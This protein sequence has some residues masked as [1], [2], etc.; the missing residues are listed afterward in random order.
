MKMIRKI[1]K[2]SAL[3][4]IITLVLILIPQLFWGKLFIVGGDDSR[5]Y[6]IFPQQFLDNFVFKIS[7]DNILGNIAGYSPRSFLAPVIYIIFLLKQIPFLNVQLLMY[8]LNLGLGFLFFY[9][10]LG[11]WIKDKKNYSIYIKIIASF[12]Y[13]FSTYLINTLYVN[14]LLAV[15]L[16]FTIP[17]SLYFFLKALEGKNIFLLL[18]SSL[19][20]SIF[21]STFNTLPWSAAVFIVLIPILI[22]EFWKQ[23]KIFIFYSLIFS[24]VTILLNLHWL[25][26]LFY[27]YFNKMGSVS[28]ID[29]YSSEQFKISSNNLIRAVTGIFGQL[30]IIFNERNTLFVKNFSIFI[31]LKE[32][33]ILT[34]VSA[35]IFIK[36]SDIIFRKYY[37]VGLSSLLLAFFFFSPSFG[38]WSVNLF[39]FLNNKIPFFSMFRN[40]YDKFSF[41]LAF[42]YSFSFAISLV[43]IV[44]IIKSKKTIQLFLLLISIIIFLNASSFIFQTK[45]DKSTF[46]SISGSFENSFYDLIKYAKT[47]KS[48][49]TFLWIPLNYPSY[50]YM[51]D[52]KNKEHFYFG[53]SP[54][55]ILTGKKDYT[56]YLSFGTG[57]EPNLGEKIFNAIERKDYFYVGKTF[58]K[59]NI[60]YIIDNK[61]KLPNE[62][63]D[64]LYSGNM[65][66][67]QNEE[68]RS[69]ILGKE[70][71][72]FDSKFILYEI[73]PKYRSNLFYLTDTIDNRYDEYK[74]V[75][76]TQKS[77]SEYYIT[78]EH[79]QEKQL[80][81]FQ[82]LY[83]KGW[84]LYLNSNNKNILYQ[85]GNNISLH[86][87]FANGWLI[88]VNDIKR[89]FSN[90]YYTENRNGSINL[91][92][93]LDYYPQELVYI[94][95]GISII[96]ALFIVFLEIF[97]LNKILK[98]K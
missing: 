74:Y 51:Q 42:A 55:S 78:L 47:L 70:I 21:S 87:N 18:L 43:I 91:N 53:T 23:K 26:P 62:A 64:F 36:K 17:C 40:M 32:V 34:I 75:K 22:Y 28:A 7:S 38:N 80:L 8:G 6:Y 15:Y 90:E 52:V 96:T 29:Y 97:H 3:I 13:V 10:F 67:I 16:V 88:D 73:N 20:F 12:L 89:K 79:I 63:K 39:I 44:N 59:L 82:D 30:N 71:K 54:F 98:K 33:F 46:N 66:Q 93:I 77:N 35:G 5:L 85:K 37:L 31:F 19:V 41:A 92:L 76:F 72:N 2:N 61:E 69:S 68:F 45:N 60:N 50:S 56:G 65:L 4:I 1:N 14:Q 57:L 84:I 25:L 48:G 24:F 95:G 94:G 81:I 27:S 49:S 11:I 9:F 58:Q 86:D 83:S